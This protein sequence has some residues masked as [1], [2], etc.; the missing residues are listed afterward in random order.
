MTGKKE[1]NDSD[2][3]RAVMQDVKPLKRRTPR[4]AASPGS[5]EKETTPIPA[6]GKK[7]QVR[8]AVAIAP[9]PPPPK[10]KQSA[11]Q[12]GDITGL[13]RR[14]GQRFKRG[15]LPVEARLDL[16]GMTQTEA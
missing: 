7:R 6:S 9:P 3:F 8:H 10:P 14:S 1:T 4:S 5:A 16:H 11:L 15:Q 13:D 12:H 2:L